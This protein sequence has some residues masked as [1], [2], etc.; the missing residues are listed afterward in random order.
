MLRYSVLFSFFGMLQNTKK[1]WEVAMWEQEDCCILGKSVWPKKI[2]A[3]SHP[4][5]FNPSGCKQSKQEK[6]QKNQH[7]TKCQNNN[8]G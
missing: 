3:E 5:G 4:D 1:R 2:V 8:C 6:E 7:K